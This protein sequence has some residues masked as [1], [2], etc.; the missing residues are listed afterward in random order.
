MLNI[1]HAVSSMAKYDREACRL[2]SDADNAT[3]VIGK[4]EAKGVT[5]SSE[6]IQELHSELKRLFNERLNGGDTQ[7]KIESR[8]SKND[9]TYGQCT[10]DRAFGELIVGAFIDA[11]VKF[12][13]EPWWRN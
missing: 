7:D 1:H 10:E 12:V 5:I 2:H 11:G 13:D 8:C 4:M 6:K 9:D 3:T